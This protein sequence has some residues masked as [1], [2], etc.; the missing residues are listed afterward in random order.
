M[1]N[2]FS[3][4]LKRLRMTVKS[5]RTDCYF[6]FYYALLRI[7]DELGGRIHLSRLSRTAHRKRDQWIL[8]YL[9]KELSPVFEALQKVDNVGET[10]PNAPIWI[11][12]WTGIETAPPLV[13]QCIRSIQCNA[14]D[15]PVHFIDEE[16]YHQFITIPEYMIKK[17]QAG[18]MGL[19][20]L[21]DYIRVALLEEYGGL[22]LDATIYCA[23]QIDNG[24]FNYPFFTC[25]SEPCDCPY[26]SKMQWVTFILGGW[27][28]NVVYQYLRK[29]FECY[30]KNNEYAIDYL[31]FDYIIELGR[32]MI[33]A[34]RAQM[35]QVPPNNPHRDDLQ[36]AMNAALPEEKWQEVIKPETALYKLSWRE[37]YQEKTPEGEKTVYRHL[38][39]MEIRGEKK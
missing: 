24:I 38:L 37:K 10:V 18:H 2:V 16:S 17:V 8:N 27:K 36:A 11:C 26:L 4:V 35:D 19:A 23:Q 33:P 25:K 21:A 30:W 29:A 7:G 31:F 3:R 32:C 9:K 39:D 15:H 6:S 20:H 12:W 22:W 28:N 13:K 14:G 1:K 34:V 5:F